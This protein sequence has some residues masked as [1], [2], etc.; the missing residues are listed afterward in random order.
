MTEQNSYWYQ[1]YIL[2]KQD[3][4]RLAE[5]VSALTTQS[6]YWY[7]LYDEEVEAHTA[8]AEHLEDA[9]HWADTLLE[10]VADLENALEELEYADEET[11][12]EYE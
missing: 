12:S 7:N 3:N 10:T 4:R 5:R 11:W 2:E 6:A 9:V 1:M 8:T